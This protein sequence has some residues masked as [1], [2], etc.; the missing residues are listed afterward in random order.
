LLD[1]PLNATPDSSA[2]SF[3]LTSVGVTVCKVGFTA[4]EK[5]CARD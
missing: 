5:I 1:S 3:V 2:K 4:I